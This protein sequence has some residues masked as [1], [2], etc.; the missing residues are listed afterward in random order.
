MARNSKTILSLFVLLPGLLLSIFLSIRPS[1]ARDPR[2]TQMYEQGLAAAQ[3]GQNRDAVNFFRRAITYDKDY[4]DAFYQLGTLYVN[5]GEFRTA[6]TW[7]NQAVKLNPSNSQAL[8]LLNQCRAQSGLGPYSSSPQAQRDPR[9]PYKNQSRYVRPE[10]NN[11]YYQSAFGAYNQNNPDPRKQVADARYQDNRN[12]RSPLIQNQEP[13]SFAQYSQPSYVQQP[14]APAPSYAQPD[15][16]QIQQQIQ[17]PVQ[18]QIQQPVAPQVAFSTPAA[19]VQPRASTPDLTSDS[20]PKAPPPRT[21]VVEKTKPSTTV[22]TPVKDKWALVIGISKFGKPEYNLE[23]AAKDATDFYNFL[24]KEA[25]FKSDHV[26]LLLN[27]EATRTN[28][29]SAFGSSWLPRLTEPGDLVVVYVSTHGTP[30]TEDDGGRNY[31]VAYDTDADDL[32]PTGVDMDEIYRRIKE[33]VKTDRVLIVLDTCYS[34]GAVPGSRALSRYTNF[35]LN[36]VK[37][38]KGHLVISSS[39]PGEK[40]WESK[41]YKNG[42]FTRQLIEALKGKQV[43]V[44]TAFSKLK[45]DVEWEVKVDHGKSQTPQIG[46]DWQGSELIISVPA[47]EPRSMGQD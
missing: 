33:G 11:T 39:S 37:L 9:Y 42:V 25:N 13:R 19:A 3:R 15:Q 2:A 6:V 41:R 44:K 16:Q 14:V 22:D 40:S 46:G 32:Y 20:A 28:I 10:T 8:L 29:M 18:Q 26:K 4:A 45:H 12:Y 5:M 34:G 30:S 31:V 36:A 35:D 47:S 27:E 21:P 23:Y 24:V 7:L 17:Q 43:D 1:E 38:G